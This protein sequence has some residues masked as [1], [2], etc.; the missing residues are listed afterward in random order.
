MKDKLVEKM[1]CGDVRAFEQIIRKYG[2]YVFCVAQNHSCGTLPRE[3]IEEI[4]N[5]TFAA[6]W[7]GRE[8]IDTNREIMPYLAVIAKNKV[9]NRLRTRKVTVSTEQ[10]GELYDKDFEQKLENREAVDAVLDAARKLT[11]RQHEIFVRFYL[12]GEPLAVIAERMGMNGPA[13]R[14]A[15]FRAREAIKKSLWEGGYFD[16]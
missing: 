10:L 14:T 16:D 15:L 12:Y 9:S 2:R 1:I 7:L 8:R 6:V 4:V 3:D 13:A 5:D 11:A